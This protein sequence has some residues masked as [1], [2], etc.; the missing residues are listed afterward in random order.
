M[1][2]MEDHGSL[3]KALLKRKEELGQR[4]NGTPSWSPPVHLL[5]IKDEDAVWLMVK[6]GARD[7]CVAGHCKALGER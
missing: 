1:L 5:Q 7:T 4:R 3:T 6:G 2:T